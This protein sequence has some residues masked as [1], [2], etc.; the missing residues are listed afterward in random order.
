MK[1]PDSGDVTEIVASNEMNE[2][3]WRRGFAYRNRLPVA[4][5]PVVLDHTTGPQDRRHSI[6]LDVGL[7]DDPTQPNA[8]HE[9]NDDQPPHAESEES[10]PGTRNG[11]GPHDAVS[12]GLGTVW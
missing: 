4:P 11:A 5:L 3:S 6:T 2:P 1:E 9:H 10:P 8:D 12:P 7:A